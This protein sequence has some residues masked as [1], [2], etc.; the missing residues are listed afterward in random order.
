MKILGVVIGHD[1]AACLVEDGRIVRYVAEERFNRIKVGL[2]GPHESL[3]YCLGDNKMSE[4]D[5]LATENATHG[6]VKVHL[7]AL[8]KA[9]KLEG[10]PLWLLDKCY[11]INRI[12][13][14]EH[15]ECH[16]ASAYYTSGFDKSLVVVA[17]GI[18]G[19]TTVSTYLAEGK[20]L[21]AIYIKTVDGEYT[22]KNDG[23]FE[24]KKFPA[25]KIESLGW[26][27]SAVTEA[28]GWRICCDEGKTMGLAPYGDPDAIPE[29]L[30]RVKLYDAGRVGYYQNSG[31]TY[32]SMESARYYQELMLKYGRENLAA[33]AQRL[34][35]KEVVNLVDEWVRKTNS[36]RIC[37]SGGVFLNV[38]V[39]QLLAEK[40]GENYWAFPLA[41][42]SGIPIGAALREYW[43]TTDKPYEPIRV[44][45][46][47]W[48]PEY[49]DDQIKTILERNKLAHKPY[50]SDYV[51][52]Q[53]LDNKIVGWFQGAM[54]AGPRAL[55]NRSILMSPL[56]ACNKDI[57]NRD[58]KFR[59]SFRPFCPSV[60]SEAASAYFDGGGE[61][62]ITA[63]NVKN[64]HIPAVTHVDNTARPQ[65]LRKEENPKFHEL[66]TQFGKLTGHPVLLN[67]S[68]NI[69][70]EPIIRTPEEA[71]RCFAGV[72]MD[73]M[74]LGNFVLEKGR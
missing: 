54:E 17:D 70:G 62:M 13:Q 35:E 25:K 60:I 19:N 34:L 11:D 41:G 44:G 5:K 55:G 10:F 51:A 39:N 45:N 47:Y 30:M 64:T 38:K 1:S 56:K 69:M 63:C 61:F 9:S 42:D 15:H 52:R 20:D 66:L 18:G 21:K 27:Y 74:V 22:R 8:T 3:S 46:L 29:E 72:G 67:T 73:I 57:I 48:G 2:C 37:T 31:R 28:L 23:A 68:L 53:L 33:A 6:I 50:E 36:D 32:Y 49:A 7:D 12:S 4:I 14:Y 71:L 40:Y 26:F 65:I 43:K 58:V 16:A 59:E 24:L